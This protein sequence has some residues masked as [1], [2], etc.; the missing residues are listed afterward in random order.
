MKNLLNDERYYFKGFIESVQYL[1]TLMTHKDMMVH[2]EKLIKKFYNSD[3]F[4]SYECGVDGN[5]IEHLKNFSNNR[6]SIEAL[7]KTGG[8]IGQTMKSGFFASELI[9]TPEPYAMAFLPISKA[10]KTIYVIVIGHQY[11]ETLPKYLLNIYLAL[12]G[13]IGTTIEKLTMIQELKIQHFNLEE[14]I[15]ELGHEITERK[16]VEE[17]LRRLMKELKRSNEELE[18]FAYV[19]SHDLQEPLR[20]IASFTQLLEQRYKDKI[21]EDANDFMTFIVEG[22]LRLQNM[23]ND[24]LTF[25]RVG[26]SGKPFKETDTNIV[27]SN[28]KSYLKTMIEE[29][30]T[31]ISI[32]PLPVVIGDE[33]LLTQLFQNLISNAI[34]F[35]REGISPQVYISGIEKKN[36]WIFCVRDNGIGIEKDDID[37]IF[38]IFQ[39]LHK[40][41]EYG[42]TGIGLAICKKIIQRHG[43]NIWVESEIGKGSTFH[44]SISKRGNRQKKL[45]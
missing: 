32:D 13:F 34:K 9:N 29:S 2:L 16:K 17:D 45:N 1:T 14:L 24:L 5:I 44:F 19:A 36:K 43:G 11:S 40:R 31:M 27:F 25:S 33:A 38:V 10:N 42:G 37:R 7:K 22:V 39:R 28:V 8:I 6:F 41:N 15:E 12:A 4:A 23:I 35:H 3:F 20:M 18:Q 21:D 30:N 26:T